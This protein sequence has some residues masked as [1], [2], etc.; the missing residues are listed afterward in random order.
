MMEKKTLFIALLVLMFSLSVFGFSISDYLYEGENVSSVV[1]KTIDVAGNT[2]YLYLLNNQPI[3]IVSN[4]EPVKNDS[5]IREV[6][7]SYYSSLYMPEQEKIEEIKALIQE[8]NNSRNDGAGTKWPGKEENECKKILG[9]RYT[10]PRNWEETYN[11][12]I[13]LFYSVATCAYYKPKGVIPCSKPEDIYDEIKQFFENSRAIDSFVEQSLEELDN[14]SLYNIKDSLELVKENVES[15]EEKASPL[16]ESKFRFPL[17]GVDECSDCYGI[18]PPIIYN[19]TA[20]DEIKDKIDELL[21]SLPDKDFAEIIDEAISQSKARIHYKEGKEDY[22]YYMQKYNATLQEI[23]KEVEKIV[24]LNKKVKNADIPNYQEIVDLYSDINESINSLNFTGFENKL[25]QLEE[26]LNQSKAYVESLYNE[27][28]QLEELRKEIN[29]YMAVLR[30]QGLSIE[31][32]E[33]QKSSLDIA[34]NSNLNKNNIAQFK[35]DYEELLNKIKEKRGTTKPEGI[36]YSLFKSLTAPLARATTSIIFALPIQNKTPIVQHSA[37]ITSLIIAGFLFSTAI[38][39][40]LLF[41]SLKRSFFGISLREK[42]VK[43]LYFAFWGVIALIGLVIGALTYLPV[44]KGFTSAYGDEV[45]SLLTKQS[46]VIIAIDYTNDTS[47][48]YRISC[49]EKMKNELEKYGVK[50]D[51]YFLVGNDCVEIAKANQTNQ[52][53]TI[54]N[55]LSIEQPL[56]LMQH[57]LESSMKGVEIGFIRLYIEGD[58]NLYKDCLPLIGIKP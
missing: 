57:S 37:I 5:V 58:D 35:Q 16:E 48:S 40:S 21:E 19:H 56:V 15:I 52:S 18:C 50:A 9:E 54:S 26:K 12:D 23:E 24:L 53:K 31:D 41:Y 46:E 44:S 49:G 14:I 20:I 30:G 42:R 33:T 7:E 4:K 22:L 3:L 39:F 6:L 25:E 55:C 28:K 1:I 27:V 51:L 2:Y 29:F 47:L 13:Y 45:L 11:N 38:I 32:L 10:L 34:Y 36:L 43:L 17:G 8:L